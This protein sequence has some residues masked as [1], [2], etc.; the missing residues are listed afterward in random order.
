MGVETVRKFALSMRWFKTSMMDASKNWAHFAARFA[1]KCL[2]ARREF[3][4][5]WMG[6][7]STGMQAPKVS[8]NNG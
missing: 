3:E 7:A 1:I 2:D 6:M 8:Q 4:S 5:R